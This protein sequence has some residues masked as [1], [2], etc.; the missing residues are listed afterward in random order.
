ML[1]LAGPEAIR[2]SGSPTKPSMN[3]SGTLA[4]GDATNHSPAT[5]L[6]SGWSFPFR[7]LAAVNSPHPGARYGAGSCEKNSDSRSESLFKPRPG[8]AQITA[9]GGA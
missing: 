9:P 4:F 1:Q 5:Q 2:D 3:H 7:H 8:A 6:L